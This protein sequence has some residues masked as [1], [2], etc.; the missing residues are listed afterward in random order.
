MDIRDE[1]PELKSV[2][3]LNNGAISLMPLRSREAMTACL[4]ERSYTGERRMGL[5]DEREWATRAKIARLINA[6][7]EDICLVGNTSD[8]L[9]IAARGLPLKEGD[10]ILILRHGFPGNAVP[11]LSLEARGISVKV[12]ESCFG[13]DATD[14]LLAAVDEKTRVLAL[15]FVEWVDGFRYNLERVGEFCRLREIFFVVDS[16]QGVGAMKL[17]VKAAAISFL[18]NGGPK[19]LMAPNGTGFIYV[20]KELLPRLAPGGLGYLGLVKGPM[21]FDYELTPRA[22]ASRL[23]AGTPNDLGIAAME[24][25]LDLILETGIGKIQERILGL[26]ARAAEGLKAKG[27]AILGDFGNN[28]R[29]GIISFEGPDIRGLYEKLAREQVIVALRKK[30]IRVSPHFFN[31]EEDIDRMLELL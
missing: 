9:N 22:D 8:G 10:Q 13:E 16:I 30:W 21:D 20:N 1:F 3:Y 15:S 2:A 25:S 18:S 26:V 19:W 6:S 12:V 4:A 28:Y 23:K 7:A 31:D 14:R 24:R 29:S 5:R 11:W 17:D 27:Y